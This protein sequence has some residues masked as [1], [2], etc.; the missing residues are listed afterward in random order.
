MLS[1]FK[2]VQNHLNPTTDLSCFKFKCKIFLVIETLGALT[3]AFHK[4]KELVH[5]SR[6]WK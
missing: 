3:A 1:V 4:V 5:T 6:L 2:N